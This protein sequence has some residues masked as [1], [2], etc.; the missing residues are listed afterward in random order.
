MVNSRKKFSKSILNFL[1]IG[2]KQYLEKEFNFY[3]DSEDELFK[4]IM[5]IYDSK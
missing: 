1:I 3:T 4:H 5:K 2:G